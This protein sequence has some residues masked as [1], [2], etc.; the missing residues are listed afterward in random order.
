L[1]AEQAPLTT[2]YVQ[3]VDSVWRG[4]RVNTIRTELNLLSGEIMWSR[5][6]SKYHRKECRA[7]FRAKNLWNP[8]DRYPA[9]YGPP[10]KAA[11][12]GKFPCLVC[13]P[14]A[15]FTSRPGQDFGHRPVTDIW[16]VTGDRLVCARCTDS[17]LL[18]PA[19]R[20]SWPCMSAGILGIT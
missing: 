17:S 16:R 12:A 7:C 14:E 5:G 19:D 15:V 13:G 9:E 20:V 10:G 4:R 11:E 6:G 8:G 3:N 1:T 2:P 18:R